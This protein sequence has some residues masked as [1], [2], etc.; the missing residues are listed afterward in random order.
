LPTSG[1][2]TGEVIDQG[3]ANNQT[4][5]DVV[6]VD[7]RVVATLLAQPTESFRTCF[8]KYGKPAPPKIGIGDSVSVSIWEAAGGAPGPVIT[9]VIVKNASP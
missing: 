2:T 8:E 5:C 9:G 6:D 3:V 7:P 1:P 4:R